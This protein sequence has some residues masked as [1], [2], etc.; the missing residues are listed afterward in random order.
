M[1]KEAALYAVKKMARDLT[2]VTIVVAIPVIASLMLAVFVLSVINDVSKLMLPI[3][4]VSVAL[5]AWFIYGLFICYYED[6]FIQHSAE[7]RRRKTNE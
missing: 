5:V 1:K 2:F 4:I 6:Y 7:R 3:G